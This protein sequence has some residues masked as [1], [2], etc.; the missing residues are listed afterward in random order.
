MVFSSHK[1]DLTLAVL[2]TVENYAVEL[3]SH[4][5]T[6]HV[7]MGAKIC[8]T[9][10]DIGYNSNGREIALRK[11]LQRNYRGWPTGHRHGTAVWDEMRV[12]GKFLRHFYSR[13]AFLLT[14]NLL[15]GLLLNMDLILF[16]I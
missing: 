15:V 5:T 13:H 12:G 3:K 11:S 16:L 10:F 9:A 14:Y 7:I 2:V 8:H 6:I 4:G 1:Y